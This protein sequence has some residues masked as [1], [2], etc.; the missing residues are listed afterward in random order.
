MKRVA[1]VT[2]LRELYGPQFVLLGSQ[3]TPG[4]RE[5][6]LMGRALSV[7]GKDEAGEVA[8]E[9][10]A[11]DAS[12]EDPFGQQVNKTYRLAD[13]FLRGSD[14]SRAIALL[15]WD[16]TVPPE[17]GDYAMFVA[18]S[19]AARSLS[20]SRKVGAALVRVGRVVA[21]GYN[22]VPAGQTPDVVAGRDTSEQFNR[23]N[24]ED[25]LRRLAC[26]GLIANAS[27]DQV[28]PAMV[29]RALAALDGGELISVIEYQRAVHV[30]AGALD[31]AAVRGVVT[32][33]TDLYVTRFPSHLCYMHALSAGVD[34][35]RYIEPYSK[36]RAREMYPQGSDERLVPYEG[37][38]PRAYTRVFDERPPPRS[39]GGAFRPV[40]PQESQPLL[41]QPRR[42]EDMDRD[43]RLAL[44]PISRETT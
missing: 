41:S 9:L 7:T 30:E 24:V 1:E 40:P 10:M 17:P 3:G 34:K 14:S 18:R 11:L 4:E 42:A 13:L 29:D 5:A 31:D 37:V 39:E 8:R 25:T 12:D 32:S 28:A 15:S 44:R 43:E 6:N 2:F 33:G 38:A 27:S 23:R 26:E 36:S 22:D 20:G 16:P 21:S 35:V 19:T